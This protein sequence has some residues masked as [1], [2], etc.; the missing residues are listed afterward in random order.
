M[1]DMSPEDNGGG[2]EIYTERELKQ[3]SSYQKARGAVAREANVS[4]IEINLFHLIDLISSSSS[5]YYYYW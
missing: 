2:L 3:F 4:I 5:Y 1:F